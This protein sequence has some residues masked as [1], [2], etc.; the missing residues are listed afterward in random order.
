MSVTNGSVIYYVADTG[1][2]STQTGLSGTVKGGGSAYSLDAASITQVEADGT[3]TNPTS[4][5]GFSLTEAG[6]LAFN[7]ND[8]AFGGLASG[9]TIQISGAYNFTNASSEA[10][11]NQF[12]ISITSDGAT[13]TATYLSGSDTSNSTVG[14]YGFTPDDDFNGTVKFSYLIKDGQGGS[15]SNTVPVRISSINDAPDALYQEIV[16]GAEGSSTIK[17]QLTSFDVDTHNQ[18]GTAPETTAYSFASALID[19]PTVVYTDSGFSG[20]IKKQDG[21]AVAATQQVTFTSL[22]VDNGTTST[23]AASVAAVDGLTLN[24]NGSWTLVT[25]GQPYS[26][27]TDGQSIDITGVYKINTGATEDESRSFRIRVSAHDIE[28][29]NTPAAIAAGGT[30]TVTVTELTQQFAVGLTTAQG[31]EGL[32]I[33]T[34]GSWEF[35]PTNNDYN[36]LSAGDIQEIEV[37]Y[38]VKDA[39][40]LSNATFGGTDSNTFTIRLSGTND[41]P[42]ATF[43]TAQTSTEDANNG[44]FTQL[45]VMVLSQ[46]HCLDSLVQVKLLNL[47]LQQSVQMVEHH[48]H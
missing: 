15:I 22:V 48:Q 10:E 11:S 30:A 9:E 40:Q 44:T 43:V 47:N 7:P 31:V 2:T 33:N 6:A 23:P 1:I 17:G 3:T 35:D 34:D 46:E 21:S 29:A 13:R 19:D 8:A 38:D 37:T 45:L 42:D 32:T 39:D 25:T 14:A 27:L 18:A 5:S 28:Q 36:Q 41:A 12:I 26:D 16:D 4:I 20:V 24:A